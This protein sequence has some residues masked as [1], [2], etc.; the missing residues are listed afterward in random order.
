MWAFSL[1][2]E[3]VDDHR[4]I[5]SYCALSVQSRAAATDPL[6]ALPPRH[7]QRNLRPNPS[8]RSLLGEYFYSQF[9]ATAPFRR[10]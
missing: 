10:P 7:H 4:Q 1:A 3:I 2:A 9:S 6:R 5:E 8:A